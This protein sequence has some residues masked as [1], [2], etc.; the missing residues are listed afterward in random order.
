MPK[1][2]MD[3]IG[4]YITKPYKD[5]FSFNCRKV[6]C[7]GLIKDAVVTLSHIPT[8]SVMRDIMVEDILARFDMLLF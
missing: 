3:H 4:L 1:L 7:L 2:F 6:K 5:I 8:K